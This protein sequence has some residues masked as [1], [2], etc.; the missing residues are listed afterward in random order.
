MPPK[1][2]QSLAAAAGAAL[3][4]G[5][6]AAQAV[7]DESTSTSADRRGMAVTVY[8]DNLALVKDARL[9]RLPAG[10]SALAW[11]EVSAK[12]RP[13]T[14]QLRNLSNPAGFRL[15]EQNFD[16]DLLT[17][18]K[19]LDKYVGREIAVI[20]T[21]AATGVET[22]ETATVLASNGDAVLKFADRVETGVTGRLAFPG[23]PGALRDRPTL[24][25]SLVNPAS[26]PPP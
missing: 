21:N 23:I 17:P 3:F 5:S 20:R 6:L 19:L 14:A 8:N 15:L 16:F 26:G 22:R 24:V 2:Q 7:Q 1:L 13:E 11:R 18:A 4:A 10:A 12:M 9:V 25:V